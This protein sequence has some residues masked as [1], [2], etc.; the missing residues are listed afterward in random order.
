MSDF[1]I[2][3]RL[4]A[5][6]HVLGRYE[7]C[8]V[9]LH[10]NAALPW[11]ILVPETT[12][13]DLLDLPAAARDQALSEC[14]AVGRF[15]KDELG[16]PKVNFGAIGNLVPQMHLHVVGRRPGDACWPAPVWGN[17]ADDRTYEAGEVGELTRRLA[18]Q[19]G[20]R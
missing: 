6:C 1:D 11:F 5:D 20:L 2:H 10:R 17:L 18:E 3:P 19:T 8:H 16:W 12:L 14:T 15:V 4:R 13:A 7:L 9:L